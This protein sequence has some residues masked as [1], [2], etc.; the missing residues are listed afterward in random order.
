MGRI[1]SYETCTPSSFFTSDIYKF[2]KMEYKH[3]SGENYTQGLMPDGYSGIFYTRGG[4]LLQQDPHD[5]EKPG[6]LHKGILAYSQLTKQ[7]RFKF[8]GNCTV[9]GVL[10]KPLGFSEYFLCDMPGMRDKLVDGAYALPQAGRLF[11]KAA[12]ESEPISLQSFARHCERALARI[13]LERELSMYIPSWLK[14][15]VSALHENGW[16]IPIH[17]YYEMSP[18]CA[19]RFQTI[20]HEKVGCSI[21][22]YIRIIRFHSFLKKYKTITQSMTFHDI[23][24]LFGYYDEA[25]L[26]H[27]MQQIINLSPQKLAKQQRIIYYG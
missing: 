6:T 1:V 3:D 5:L 8:T 12:S 21:K 22:T 7:L 19:R 27:D 4:S 14:K 11:E 18:V 2:Y 17:E 10:F 9:Y 25:H 16:K 24:Q 15:T 23:A 13:S 20:F 26:C